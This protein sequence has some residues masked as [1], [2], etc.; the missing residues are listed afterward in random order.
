MLSNFQNPISIFFKIP[1][2]KII[3]FFVWALSFL[4]FGF[5]FTVYATKDLLPNNRFYPIK[6]EIE[7]IVAVGSAFLNKEVDWQ[8]KLINRRFQEAINV[9][10]SSYGKESLIRLE[11][12][13]TK[14]TES[15]NNIENKKQKKEAAERYITELSFI[16]E[17]LKTQ[18]K[19][20]FKTTYQ[21]PSFTS[22]QNITQL[23]TSTPIPPPTYSPPTTLNNPPIQTQNINVNEVNQQIEHTQQ[24][25]EE[26]I[27]K[28]QQ[29]TNLP[30]QNESPIP[31]TFPT[32]TP[33][34]TITNSPIKPT[35]IIHNFKNF[36]FNES[37]NSDK[38]NIDNNTKLNDTQNNNNL[39]E[40]SFKAR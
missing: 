8:I 38:E 1:I 13:I 7:K 24:T 39:N 14:T 32:N 26:T 15:I 6:L 23:E 40:N 19:K 22:T 34:P 33:T 27:K 10:N 4:I 3:D 28:I 17:D 21:L 12:Y 30:I 29:E 2:K 20:L 18:Q 36:K 16:A 9:L 25:I 5:A 31:T 37:N 35:N 11:V